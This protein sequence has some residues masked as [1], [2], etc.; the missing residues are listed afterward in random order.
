VR[1]AAERVDRADRLGLPAR[2]RAAGEDVEHGDAAGY[3]IDHA[4]AARS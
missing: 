2:A 3:W 4:I 1:V